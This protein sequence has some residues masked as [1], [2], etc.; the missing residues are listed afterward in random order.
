MRTK[1]IYPTPPPPGKGGIVGELEGL[2]EGGEVDLEGGGRGEGEEEEEEEL[3]GG[4]SG[5]E[6]MWRI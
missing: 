1:P 3:D 4:G 2:L 5:E 6:R